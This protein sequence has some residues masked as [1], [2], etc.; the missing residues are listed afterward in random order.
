MKNPMRVAANLPISEWRNYFTA[1]QSKT[2]SQD[3]GFE[4]FIFDLSMSWALN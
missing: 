3:D 4:K 1:S 2:F